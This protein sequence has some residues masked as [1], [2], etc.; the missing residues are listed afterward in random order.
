MI[1][2]LKGKTSPLPMT[3]KECIESIRD[4]REVYP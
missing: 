1:D 3:G 2:I 4:G